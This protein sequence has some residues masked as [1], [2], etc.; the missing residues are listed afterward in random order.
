MPLQVAMMMKQWRYSTKNLIKLL[1]R[2][3]VD[4][5]LQ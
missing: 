4:I 2:N 1:T 3:P 5:T